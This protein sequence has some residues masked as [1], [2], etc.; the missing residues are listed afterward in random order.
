MKD[1]YSRALVQRLFFLLV[2]N[3]L[4]L[5]AIRFFMKEGGSF[6]QVLLRTGPN[7]APVAIAGLGMTGI[8]FTG[9]IDLSVAS[10]MVVAGTVFGI[11]VS[12]GVSPWFCFA[13]CVATAWSLS[14][15]NGYWV[16]LL[17]IPA[18]IITLAGLALYRGLALIIAD[19]GLPA[20]SGNISVP[21]ERYHGPGKL[22]AGWILLLVL[23]LAAAWELFAKSPRRWLALGNSEEACRLL[24]VNPGPVLQ[25][26]FC[27]GGVFLGLAA[28]IFTTRVQAIEPA[29][30]A[31]GFE[32][33]VIGAVVLGGTNIFGGEGSYA[34]TV[35]GAIFLYLILELLIYAGV[36]PY[37]QELIT[38]TIIVAVIGLDCA[39]HRKEKLMAE[40]A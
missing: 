2:G 7:V 26:A 29:R 21:D 40:L 13:A 38:G 28:L 6:S 15:A 20:F 3:L 18:I 27:V 35:L 11:L 33:Q 34:G 39:L 14:M 9:A 22:H 36:S 24:G 32:L 25:S 4:L 16:R 37:F 31:L 8:I 1:R 17:K 10:V 30:M 23:I 5:L 19:L 12:H